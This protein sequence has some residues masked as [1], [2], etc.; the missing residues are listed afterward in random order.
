MDKISKRIAVCTLAVNDWYN[1]IVKY[2]VKT[3]K[4]YAEKHG[5]DFYMPN[6]EIQTLIELDKYTGTFRGYPWYK[7]T[8]IK[9][10]LEN[11]DYVI[12]I[13]SDGHVLKPEMSMEDLI[14]HEDNQTT[15]DLV[16][17]NDWN[18]PVN[19]G[20]MIVK[21]T[22]FI[23]SLLYLILHNHF[24]YDEN[25]HEQAS[26]CKIYENNALNCRKKILIK[27]QPFLFCYW[28]NYH[29]GCTFF[30]HIARCS[31]DRAGFIYTLDKFCPIPMEEDEGDEHALR[32]AWLNNNSQ[33][34]T[35][36]EAWINGGRR[37][38]PSTRTVKYNRK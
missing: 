6:D 32:V 11:Y 29:A 31:E 13:D 37:V 4:N 7:I 20:I 33:C 2:G 19:T 10:I 35:T 25:F 5:Y 8:V 23:Y 38:N 17:S 16:C 26:L 12:W 34:R 27:P 18:C 30:I 15:Y 14:S 36:I 22:P 3:I 28:A 1:E 21:N 24:S 9:N